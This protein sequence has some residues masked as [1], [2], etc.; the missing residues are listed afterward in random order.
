MPQTHSSLPFPQASHQVGASDFYEDI[1]LAYYWRSD[2]GP[3]AH[4]E[5]DEL[6]E[7]EEASSWNDLSNRE[8]TTRVTQGESGPR[9]VAVVPVEST[10]PMATYWNGLPWHRYF[11]DILSIILAIGFLS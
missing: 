2:R 10:T 3:P 6:E 5:N 7:T 8:S 11:G 4:T 1:P 9:S